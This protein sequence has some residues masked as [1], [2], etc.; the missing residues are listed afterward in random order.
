MNGFLKKQN[1]EI[2]NSNNFSVYLKLVLASVFVVYL[3]LTISFYFLADDQ[4]HFRK[5]GA[6]LNMPTPSSVSIE[7]TEGNEIVQYFKTGIERLESVSV[8]WS[9][10]YR[11]NAGMATLELINI[12]ANEVLAFQQFD[13]STI[14]EGGLTTL[15]IAKPIENL[16]DVTLALRITTN[17]VIGGGASPLISQDA[18]L[19]GLLLI[20]G[21]ETDGFLCL[22]TSGTDY[23]TIGQYYWQLVIGF[24]LL[25]AI[26]LLTTWSRFKKGKVN[27]I[28]AAII[29]VRKYRFLIKQLVSR[30]F[31]QKYKR[32]VLG[33]F[34]SFLNPLL[35]MA[36]QYFIFSTIF[37][38]DIEYYPAY[39]L[40][41]IVAFNFF[42]EACSMGMMS[43]VG[44]ASLITK[45]HMPKYI[46]P[47]SRVISSVINL[48]ISCIPLVLVS[49]LT[50]VRFTK[51]AI[52]AI[53]FIVC[54][55]IFSL[56]V[57]MLLAAAIVFFRDVQFLWGVFSMIWMY[58]TPIFYPESILPNN[59][60]FVL[61][62]NPLYH[63]V[64]AI[65]TCLLSGISP[66]PIMYVKCMAMALASFIIGFL[67]FKKSQNKFVL[68]L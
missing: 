52:L 67:I 16:Y 1:K 15:S 9:T 34:W 33:V 41:G 45:V 6:E 46:Y 64:T 49:L 47:L 55:I 39:L 48:L 24:G 17:S 22:S 57:C 26:V 43:I 4:L 42:S 65:R 10:Y 2:E 18:N 14:T 13:V 20:N 19:G 38:S 30:D 68:Y 44:N 53:Y 31:K 61:I 51:A 8:E 21:N 27:K 7:L 29:A 54:L 59:F 11:T 36:V 23:T 40:I 56:G 3:V 62:I 50:G 66:E 25:L 58:A 63:I 12:D 5:S 28:V 60:K 35:T 37:K 32:S